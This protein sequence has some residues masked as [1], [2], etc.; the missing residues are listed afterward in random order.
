MAQLTEVY[1]SLRLLINPYTLHMELTRRWSGRQTTFASM[2]TISVSG[3]ERRSGGLWRGGRW[4]LCSGRAQS[5]GASYRSALPYNAPWGSLSDCI[6]ENR[7]TASLH[8]VFY[9]FLSIMIYRA[10][11]LC[12]HPTITCAVLLKAACSLLLYLVSFEV[13]KS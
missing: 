4:S 11:L 10:I 12:C 2:A 5:E 1:F 9:I 13:P 3:T 7:W 6:T 8:L